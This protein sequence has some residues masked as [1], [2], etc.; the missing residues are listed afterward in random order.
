V[1][2][3]LQKIMHPNTCIYMHF[4]HSRCC[5]PIWLSGTVDWHLL[6]YFLFWLPLWHFHC[7]VGSLWSDQWLVS[8]C[9]TLQVVAVYSAILFFKVSWNFLKGNCL[10]NWQV[11]TYMYRNSIYFFSALLKHSLGQ[12][13][14]SIW[15][16][17]LKLFCIV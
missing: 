11:I 8:T 16:L 3:T 9:F 2:V 14:Q 1:L 13:T 4:T 12:I 6:I 7:T 10:V 17:I 15:H 5:N